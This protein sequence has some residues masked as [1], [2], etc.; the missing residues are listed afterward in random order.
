MNYLKGLNPEQLEVVNLLEGPILVLAG[1][2]TGKT[3][4]LSARTA[5][6]LQNKKAM[7]ENILILTYTNSAAKAVKE[8]LVKIIGSAG[9]DVVT[10]TFH[11]FANSILLDSK[12]AANYIQERIQITDIEKVRALEYILDHTKGIDA[13]RPFR[14][15]YI[16]RSEIEQKLSE[17]KKEGISP[18][19]FERYIAS[20]KPDDIYVEEKHIPR[21]KA[22]AVVYRLYEEYK[23]GKNKELFDD[24]GR[25]DFDDMI[26]FAIEAL[27]REKG[28]KQAFGQQYKYIMVDEYQDTNGAQMNLL[29]ELVG[30]DNPNICCVG[31]D[32]Q[33]IYRFQGA[34][35]GN[36]K[37]LQDRFPDIKVITLKDNYRSTKE[38]IGLSYKII[39][40]LPDSERMSAKMLNPKTGYAK[41]SIEFREFSTEAEELL[42]ITQKVKEIKKTTEGS[43]FNDIAILVRRRGDILRVI[44]AFLNAGIPYATDGKED[45]SSEKRVRQMIDVLTLAHLRDTADFADKDAAFYRVITSDYLAISFN[46]VLKFISYLK[47]KKKAVREKGDSSGITFFSEF[48]SVFDI[49]DK[50]AAPSKHQTDAL[51]ISKEVKFE[52]P[53]VLHRAAWVIKRLIDGAETRPVHDIL[54]QYI[55]DAEVFKYILK[56]YVNN[57]VLKIRDLRSLSSFVNMVKDSDLSNPAIRLADFVGEIETRKEHNMP[58]AGSL[59]TMTQEGVRI[60]T[61]HGSK[62]LEFHTVIIPFCLQDK[63]WPL[64]PRTDSIPLPPEIFKAKERV[65]EKHLLKELSLHDEIRLFYVAS[66]RAKSNLIYTASPTENAIRSS[67]LAN[68]GLDT[69]E[70]GAKTKEESILVEALKKSEKTDPFIGTKTILKDIVTDLSLSP[71]SLNNYIQCKRK[72]FYNNVLMLPSEKRLALTFGNCVHKA[73]EITYKYLIENDKFPDFGFF[74]KAFERELNYQGVEKSIRLGCL[75]QLET[76]KEWFERESKA[77]V[78]PMGLEKKLAVML[79]D[80]LIFTGNYDKTELVDDKKKLVRVL[81]YKTGVPD[82]H[83]KRLGSKSNEL[84]SDECE[85]YL[86]QLVSYKLLFDRDKGQNRGFKISEGDLVFVEP[87]KTSV[88]KYGLKKGEFITKKV[89]LTDDMVEELEKVIKDVWSKIQE[90]NFDKLVKRDDSKCGNC[91][92][93]GICWSK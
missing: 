83:I 78:R 71:T 13:I 28:L 69:A 80:S 85:G 55:N 61:A 29:F 86:R 50:N 93:D 12:E 64:K 56:S 73:L 21:L 65:A 20:L 11:S 25:Y 3:H 39:K 89:G 42:F 59:V 88:A 41:K 23:G 4:L 79:D 22:L 58:L 33:S 31:D 62:G 76:L 53:Y 92:F 35:V 70:S 52:N 47:T 60:F 44:D 77:P 68:I 75:R 14:A 26:I 49:K 40:Y 27:R 54:L 18:H 17:L 81:D 30:H 37:I 51:R 87:A 72:F 63:N 67:Y 7:P 91:D 9:Y 48:L 10:G 46:D 84:G 82:D 16:Y 32:D 15:P 1:P 90:L 8:R 24:R 43:S 74:K 34:S 45:I 19:D 57:E 5:N 38:I 6:I 2:G 66:T 36:F